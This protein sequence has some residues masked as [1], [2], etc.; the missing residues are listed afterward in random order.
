MIMTNLK[1]TIM[2]TL[3]NGFNVLIILAAIIV[4][5]A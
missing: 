4:S 1:G 2:E 3:I 5:Q